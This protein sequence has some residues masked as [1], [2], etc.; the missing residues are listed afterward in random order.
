MDIDLT[1]DGQQREKNRVGGAGLENL[2][3]AGGDLYEHTWEIA[4]SSAG[5]G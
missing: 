5:D 4:A 1:G 3:A 2:V